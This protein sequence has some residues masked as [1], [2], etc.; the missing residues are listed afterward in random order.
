MPA[1][2]AQTSAQAVAAA[3]VRGNISSPAGAPSA[4]ASIASTTTAAT[5]TAGAASSNASSVVVD[6]NDLEALFDDPKELARELSALAG[7]SAG[8][9]GG[10]IYLL[11]SQ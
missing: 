2:L 8:P 3:A 10:Q 1:A 9:D 4:G 7:P 5:T 6:D 11:A